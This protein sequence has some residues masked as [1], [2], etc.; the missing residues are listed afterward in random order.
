[1]SSNSTSWVSN[2]DK[3][4]AASVLVVERHLIGVERRQVPGHS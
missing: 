1:L 4:P 3:F 2:D